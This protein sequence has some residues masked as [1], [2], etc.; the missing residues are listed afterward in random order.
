MGRN[1]GGLK[2]LTAE[3][4]GS[5]LKRR[6]DLPARRKGTRMMR[7]TSSVIIGALALPCSTSLT[8]NKGITPA[9]VDQIQINRGITSVPGV[10]TRVDAAAPLPTSLLRIDNIRLEAPRHIEAWPSTVLKFD[11][12]NG[13]SRPLTDLVLEISIFEKPEPD[14]LF[15]RALV[16]P[17]TIRGN[18]VLQARY[19]LNYEMLLRNL[20]SDCECIADVEVVSVRCPRRA[21]D[22]ASVVGHVRSE[23]TE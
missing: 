8:A 21:H 22:G 11:L 16:R 1:F 6:R 20:S 9:P 19:T 15:G 7:R 4:T 14:H 12:F 5:T 10:S 2:F 17:F 3:P 18:V 13:A 23:L